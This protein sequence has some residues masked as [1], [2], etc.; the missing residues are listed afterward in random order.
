MERIRL[1]VIEDDPE[2]ARLLEENLRIHYAVFVAFNAREGLQ[3]FYEVQPHVVLVDLGLPDGDGYQVIEQI[4][5]LSQVP[6]LILSARGATQDVVRGLNLGA[7]D[8]LRKPF[9]LEELRARIQALLRRSNNGHE[10][11]RWFYSDEFL[12]I[13]LRAQTVRVNGQPLALTPT[14]YR[15]LELLVRYAGRTVSYRT[16]LQQVWGPGYENSRNLV[17]LYIHYL[18][19]KL[20]RSSDGHEYLRADW[21]K[22][23][24]F[25]PRPRETVYSKAT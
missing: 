21:G 10:G 17:S 25:V 2:A 3:R 5:L 22:G 18:R 14:E 12:E 20:P 1:L 23:Y 16:I 13:D 9:H 8:Y 4:R 7:D 15:L 6:I 19:Q 24:R 11:E